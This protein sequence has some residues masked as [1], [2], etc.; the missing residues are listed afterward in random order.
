[1]DLILIKDSKEKIFI[2]FIFYKCFTQDC[3]FSATV[4]KLLSMRV[5]PTLRNTYNKKYGNL[6][7][8]AVKGYL[9]T[10]TNGGLKPLTKQK[11]R[12]ERFNHSASIGVSDCA[13]NAFQ[14]KE[15]HLAKK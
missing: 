4:N 11:V 5:L 6:W 2:I 1:M 15:F 3:L 13:E 10:A 12:I 14:Q 9:N 7:K 8:L